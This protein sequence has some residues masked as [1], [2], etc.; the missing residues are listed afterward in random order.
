M[1]GPVRH[2][3][4]T[5]FMRRFRRC[6]QFLLGVVVLAFSAAAPAEP[7]E[8]PQP[9]THVGVQELAAKLEVGDVVFI[10]VSALPFKKVA[11]ATGSWTNHVGIVID[12]S[13]SDPVI[14]ES[15]FPFSR[16]T[17]LSRF[18]ARSE[19]GRVEVKRLVVPLTEQQRGDVAAAARARFHIL[20]DTGF[21]LHSRREFCSRYVRE[22]LADAA[23]VE[24]GKVEDFSSLLK[25]NPDTDLQFWRV[26]YFNNIPW[27]RETVSPASQL[28]DPQLATVFDGF[29]D[30]NGQRVS[31][32]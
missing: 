17:T 28:R 22:V 5:Q 29:A 27:Q 13:G 32:R 30:E 16:S 12:A 7:A 1:Q 10:R 23:G 21:D 4:H 11:Q 14:G 8:D 9:A 18:V 31:S 15:T 6:S 25:T 26:W 2:S 3:R 20:Y 24:I 19:S